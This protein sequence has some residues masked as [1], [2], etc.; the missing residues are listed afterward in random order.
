M[1]H[2]MQQAVEKALGVSE[3]F[4]QSFKS[5]GWFLDD[6]I[7]RPINHLPMSERMQE[8]F[9]AQASLARRR[10]EYQPLAIVSLMHGIRYV[11]K[12]AA[13]TAASP[14][15]LYAVPFPGQGQQT[16]FRTEMAKII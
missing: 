12:E 11:V 3:N 2:Y 5:Y 15:Q 14:A 1:T 7:L 16:R 6:L 8:R 10:A 13:R 9:N 4:L